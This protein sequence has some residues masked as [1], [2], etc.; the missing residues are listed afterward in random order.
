VTFANQN[1]PDHLAHGVIVIHDQDHP[2]A[3]LRT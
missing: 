3:S 1:P 2:G